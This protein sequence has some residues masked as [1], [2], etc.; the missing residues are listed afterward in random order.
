MTSFCSR[1]GGRHQ[2]E[3]LD[4]FTGIR[5]GFREIKSIIITYHQVNS[6]DEQLQ[7]IQ[8]QMPSIFGR[9][10][11]MSGQKGA[12]EYKNLL[13]FSN[14]LPQMC[15]STEVELHL[16]PARLPA[17]LRPKKEILTHYSSIFP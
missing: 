16:P 1:R 11:R 12:E 2:S 3:L 9:F 8:L 5:R 14:T 13:H 7:G 4:F 17:Y 10:T 6:S 15:V